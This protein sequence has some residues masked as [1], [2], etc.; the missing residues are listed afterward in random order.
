MGDREIERLILSCAESTGLG[1]RPMDFRAC[2]RSTSNGVARHPPK[3][4]EGS[5]SR[6]YSLLAPLGPF[7][8]EGP[9][10]RG[11]PDARLKIE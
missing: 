9:G 2:S 5:D 3:G 7:G 8:G 11:S 10:V 4:G 6:I 1:S